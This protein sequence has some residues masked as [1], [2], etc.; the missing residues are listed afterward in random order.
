[1]ELLA[2]PNAD[3]R[4][5]YTLMSKAAEMKHNQARA[6]LAWAR[7]LGHNMDFDFAYAAKEFDA[8]AEEGLP[9]ANIV[10]V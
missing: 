4:I 5:V 2:K 10:S 6:E 7:V 1:M 9:E 8:L 3:K